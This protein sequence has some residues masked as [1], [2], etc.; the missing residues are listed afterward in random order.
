MQSPYNLFQDFKVRG[1]DI[2]VGKLP[3]EI[4]EETTEWSKKYIKY[5]N[6]S[7]S[8]LRQHNNF[9]KNSFQISILR[10][11]VFDSYLLPFLNYLG[12]YY[13]HK[14]ENIPLKKLFR[15]VPIRENYNHFDD[16][17]I[18]INYAYKE[19]ENPMHIHSGAL[20]GIIYIK[21]DFNAPTYFNNNGRHY[22]ESGDILIFPSTLSHK[23]E[24]LRDEQERITI[25]FNMDYLGPTA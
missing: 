23:V 10:S 16:V 6:H 21:N 4:L 19:D 22:G 15:R 8:F 3:N 1:N 7:L 24:P 11:D 25:A 9:G 18:W 13:V 14:H 12:E 17:D 5:K 2:L 20:S